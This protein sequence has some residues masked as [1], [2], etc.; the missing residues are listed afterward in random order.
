[1]SLPAEQT[2]ARYARQGRALL[3]P[4]K[5][6]SRR[7]DATTTAVIEA[8]AIPFARVD[9]SAAALLRELLPWQSVELLED[10]E[11]A[12]GLPNCNESPTD[13]E[14][15]QAALLSHL[16]ASGGQSDADFKAIAAALGFEV[17]LAHEYLPATCIGP[18][19]QPVA[20]IEW[21]FH[22]KVTGD[23][24]EELEDLLKCRMHQHAHLYGSLA[25]DL[26]PEE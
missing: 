23:G 22:K 2:I 25:F 8:A 9:E 20:D 12:T 19:T 26:N 13:V 7:E 17:E 15:R 11:R 5:A 4:G 24:P 18:C 6:F 3:P 16:V 21:V 1:M 10:W 14:G